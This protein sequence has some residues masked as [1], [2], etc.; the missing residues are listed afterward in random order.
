ME[1]FELYNTVIGEVIDYNRYGCYVR[2]LDTDKIVFYFGC[3]RRGD[4]VQLSIKRINV[5]REQVICTLD[6]V[7]E[8]AA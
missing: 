8:Y 3:G 7:I 1:T 6:S 5:E 2:D 4:K